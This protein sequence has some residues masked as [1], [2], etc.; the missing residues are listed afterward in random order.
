MQQEAS[1]ELLR[2]E[3][4]LPHAEVRAALRAVAGQETDAAVG[5]GED[6]AVGNADAMRV[7]GE[8]LADCKRPSKRLLRVYD[9][10][11]EVEA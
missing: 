4:L 5:D 11:L 8:V 1:D 2:V 3:R 10:L 7:A 9:P 6:A